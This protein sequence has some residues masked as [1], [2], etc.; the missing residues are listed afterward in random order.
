[1]PG[2]YDPLEASLQSIPRELG[3]TPKVAVDAAEAEPAFRIYHEDKFFGGL[4]A[5]S[6]RFGKAASD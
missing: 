4:T 3:S 5:S 6:F 1:M 2:V